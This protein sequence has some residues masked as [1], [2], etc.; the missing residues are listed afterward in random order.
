MAENSEMKIVSIS[1]RRILNSHVEFTNEFVIELSD[2]SIGAGAAP[3]GETISVYED[4]SIT[5]EPDTILETIKRDRILDNRHTQ[6]TF[7]EHLHKYRTSFGNNNC[8]ALSLAF[9]NARRTR[10]SVFELFDRQDALPAA[11][12]FCLNILNGGHHAYT[13]PVLSDFHEYIL[14]SRDNDIEEIIRDHREIQRAVH[15]KLRGLETV[16]VND[17]PVSR[18]ATRDNRECIEFLLGI[19]DGL[20]LSDKYDLMI[21]ASGGDLKTEDGYR[22]ALTDEK[23]RSGDEFCEYWLKLIDECGLRFLEDP[24]HEQDYDNWTRLTTNQNVCNIIGDNFY[25]SDEKKIAD[26]AKHR[27]THGVIIKPNQAGTVSAVIRAVEA[28]RAAKQIVITSHRSISTESVFLSTL[29]C[30]FGVEYIKIGPLL[31]D[32]SSIIRLNEIIRLTEK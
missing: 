31:T 10:E 3:R 6:E 4:K 25:S 30:A 5:I 22:L 11:P 2:G 7:D 14:V 19:R 18:F 23:L 21:D 13:N 15:E 12:K 24:L 28:A 8:L 27:Y 32:Y 29:T 17:N 16:L 9:F 26:G 1:H 20:G